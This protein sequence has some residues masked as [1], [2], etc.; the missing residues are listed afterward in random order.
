MEKLHLE[1]QR[2]KIALARLFYALAKLPSKKDKNMKTKIQSKNG[3]KIININ[4]RKA[5]HEKCLNCSG[6]SYKNVELCLLTNCQLY[7]FRSGKGKQDPK[8]RSKA[9]RQ[10]CLWCC[11]QNQAE[12]RKCTAQCCPLHV[13]RKGRLEIN[14]EILFLSE[15]RPYRSRSQQDQAETYI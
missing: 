5:V 3:H 15:K 8:F 2:T 11:A 12:V 7:S 13:Y 6:W 9:I 10:Y 4:R 14:L 1:P